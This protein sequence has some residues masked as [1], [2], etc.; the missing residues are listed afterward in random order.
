MAVSHYNDAV[1]SMESR[2]I[3]QARKL[4][5][6]GPALKQTLPETKPVETGIRQL[7]VQME[8]LLPGEEGEH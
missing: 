2:F 5:N 1:A 4:Y 6:L 7:G 8:E 3:P